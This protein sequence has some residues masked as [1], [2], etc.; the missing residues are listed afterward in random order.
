MAGLRNSLSTLEDA[1]GAP[2]MPEVMGEFKE[3]R[4]ERHKEESSP[5]ERVAKGQQG[6]AG[7]PETVH[8]GDFS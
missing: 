1:E 3:E 4:V 7:L 2:W 8:H 5:S 6:R